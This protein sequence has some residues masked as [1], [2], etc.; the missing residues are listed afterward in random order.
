MLKILL[1][2]LLV[3]GFG[4]QEIQKKSKTS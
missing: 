3:L 1:L 2:S 4:F